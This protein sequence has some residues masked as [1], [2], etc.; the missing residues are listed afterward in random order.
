MAIDY[1]VEI[2]GIKGESKDSKHTEQIDVLSFSWGA[3]QP[4]TFANGSGGTGGK[5]AM[6]DFSFTMQTCAAT[7]D[8]MK[9]CASGK[10]IAKAV[11]YCRKS[12]G[13][14]GQAEYMTWTFSPIII[15]SYQT[16]GSSGAEIPIDSVTVN[17]GKV[18]VEYKKQVDDKGT[19]QTSGNFG[20]DLE[21][22]A[23]F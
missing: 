20:W 11:L 15:S 3:H 16:G 14:G 18:K 2:D 8:L 6:S 1:F 13:D 21:K 17:Y 9:A 5:V 7:P 12:T 4:G 22:N 10:H 23:A 19:L